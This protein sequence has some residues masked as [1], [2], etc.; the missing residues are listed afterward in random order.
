MDAGHEILKLCVDVGGSITGE[1]GV[2]VEKID[3]IAWMFS[4]ADLALM[5]KI[6][7]VF[8]KNEL[9]NPGKVLPTA[10]RCWEVDNGAKMVSAA[11]GAAV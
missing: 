11:R 9:C 4:E 5:E 1:H 6:K 3:A 8:N 2:G 10:K 7:R